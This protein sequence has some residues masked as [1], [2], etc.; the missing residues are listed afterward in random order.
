MDFLDEYFKYENNLTI[1]GLTNELAFLYVINLYQKRHQN[2][3]L[4]TSTLY[5][6]NNFYNGIKFYLNDTYLF[7]MDDFLTSA[8]LATSPEL[9]T[10]RIETLEH[11]KNKTGIIVTNLM[12]YLKYLTD[13]KVQNKLN[14]KLKKDMDIN[15]EKLIEILEELGYK[16]DTIVT[17]TGEYAVRGFVI[18]IFITLSEHPIRLEFFGN[19]IESIR[20]FDENTQMS[21]STTDEITL[22][23]NGEIKTE[24]KSSL[25]DYAGNAIVVTIDESRIKAAY[26]KLEEEMFEFRVAKNLPSDTR[27]M[28][29]LDEINPKY[30]IYINFLNSKLETKD[31][32][33]IESKE[34]PNFRS[35][36]EK[37]QEQCD[38]WHRLG[39][40]IIFFLPKENQRRQIKELIN[41]PHKVEPK[42][43]TKGFI[44][45][46]KVIISAN[47]IE[48]TRTNEIKYKNSYKIGRKIKDL[49]ALNLGD[50]VVHMA[51]GIGIYNGIK[52]L[53]QN[54][55]Q[56]DYI[57]ILYEGNDKV[58]VPV[59]KMNTILKYASKDGLKP[60][61]NKL[62]STTWAKTKRAVERKIKDI[63]EEL[64]K[65]YAARRALQGEKY[66]TN[67]MEQTFAASFA[68]TPTRDQEKAINEIDKDL[69][70]QVPMDRL[71]CGDVG[72]GKTEVAFRAM[73]KTV[74]NNK[75]VF[76]LCPTTI[77]SK[78]Q[79]TSAME[80]FKDYPLNIELL[81]RFTSTKDTKRILKGLEEGTIDIVFGTHRLLS[82]DIKFKKLGLLVVDEEQRFGVTHK[83]KIKQ[84]KNDVNVL[85]LSAT[86]IPRT[87]KMAMSGLR[88]LSVID[89][90][91]V[92]RYPIQT[93]VLEEQDLIVKDAIYKELSR[94]GQ[95]FV[96]YNNINELESISSKLK[97][98]VPEARIITAHGRMTKQEL[99][100]IMED[101]IDYKYDI[102]VCTTIIETG[103]D[104]PNANTLIIY[105]AD[106]F[107]LS[108]LY[109]IRGRVGRSNKIAYAY[110]LYNKSKMLNDVAIKRLEAI[111]EFTEL[112][113]GYRIA[114][115]D[116]SIRGAGDILGSEQ[117]GFVDSVGINLYMQ[118]IEEEM[119]KLKGEEVNNDESP[120]ALINVSTHISDDYVKDDEIK[121]E[122][123]NKI[124]EIESKETLEQIKSELEDRFGKV[125]ESL[126]I[127]MY[128][129]WFEKLASSLNI[130]R[131]TQTRNFFEL[132]LPEDISN[133]LKAD[134]LFLESYN[135]NPNLKFKYQNKR[136]KISLMIKTNDKHFLYTFVPLL[137]LIKTYI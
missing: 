135:I 130:K 122:I 109:Q 77:L 34:I 98:L 133:N 74:V 132:E 68:Y 21:L 131:V 24:N 79:Y 40:E 96:L 134:K 43:L 30:N 85:T 65:L 90:A 104:I 107:G 63:S 35:N 55:L 113:S 103:I 88:D 38:S 116:L 22:I 36:F 16:R 84:Y 4:L 47:D 10:T 14:I 29:S 50:Y 57:E 129:E 83:E 95:I 62:N 25:Y 118:M 105:N 2:V 48:E 6:A 37:I 32:L 93:Y 112:G 26:L 86:P 64:L 97:K 124:N 33:S 119:K 100:N 52:T 80:R 54:G 89:T 39:Y 28:F 125:D 45:D 87:L 101:F 42:S 60:K 121:I 82:D 69:I 115:R 76:Y 20:Y 110:L 18:D 15:R 106:H 111:K 126:I 128:E 1:T 44:I 92:N 9:K 58:Y 59:E 75:Q 120:T 51:H 71:L 91:P 117:A 31:V 127:Y 123:H 56:K 7:P 3:I 27:F 73:F 136:I 11:L 137:E 12:G 99:E 49:N 19:T 8:A 67:E 41:V 70:S 5:E 114:M 61:I 46:K 72:F 13:T 23:N 81:N 108:Q 53:T 94:N 78:Q 66:V 102:L 17:S